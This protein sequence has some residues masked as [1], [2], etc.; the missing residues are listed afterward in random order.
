MV[1]RVTVY[2][3]PPEQI[4]EAVR[5]FRAQVMP[6]LRDASG[7]RGFVALLDRE[8]GRS[9]GVTFWTTREAA[10]EVEAGLGELRDEVARM[11]GTDL[12]SFD[13]Y[14]VLAVDSLSLD[15]D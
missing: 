13:V 11:A 9:L 8:R 1:A 6:W 7:F 12:Q 5:V 14:D 3:G 4:E 15:R 10:A 2:E